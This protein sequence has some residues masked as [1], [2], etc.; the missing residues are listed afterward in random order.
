MATRPRK[1][2]GPTETQ[3]QAAALALL[4]DNGF[5]VERIN[6]GLARG[7]YG[8]IIHLACKGTPDLLLE[9]PYGWIE[10][11]CPGES[12]NPDQEEWHAWARENGVPHTIAYS[13]EEA[14]VFALSLRSK[15]A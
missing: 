12:L 14:L 1:P 10:M 15:A 3:L 5:R 4:R 8:G 2:K 13:P 11:K 6:S 9:W 7:L